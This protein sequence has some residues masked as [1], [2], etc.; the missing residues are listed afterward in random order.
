ML[1]GWK[2]APR[3]VAMSRDMSGCHRQGVEGWWF[4]HWWYFSWMEVRMLLTSDDV[5]DV[6]H[7]KESPAPNSAEARRPGTEDKLQTLVFL[8]R[9]Q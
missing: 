7:G 2:F 3:Y 6:L 1:N 9:L 4:W 8:P 5:Q